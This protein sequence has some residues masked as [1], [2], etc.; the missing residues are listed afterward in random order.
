M[1]QR[2]SA[3]KSEAAYHSL[4]IGGCPRRRIDDLFLFALRLPITRKVDR[5]TVYSWPLQT[6]ARRNNGLCYPKWKL[7]ESFRSNSGS[8]AMFAAIWR[9]WSL[10]GSLAAPGLGSSRW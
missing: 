4:E 8:F 9:A 5:A 1:G 6:K 10:V 3:C 7:G 2:G